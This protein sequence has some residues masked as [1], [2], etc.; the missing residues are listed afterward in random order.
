MRKTTLRFCAVLAF[1]L[2]AAVPEPLDAGALTFNFE[3]FPDRT[4][5]TV[6]Y[7]GIAFTNGIILSAGVTLNEFEFPPHSGSNITSDNGGPIT[8]GFA[9]RFQSFSGYF[10]YGVPITIQAF[11]ASD[12]L[13]AAAASR[14]SN[15]EALSGVTGSQPNELLAVSSS[16]ANIAKVVITGAAGGT[17][18]TMDDI[19][20]SSFSQCDLNQ[21]GNVN[22]V[23][24]QGIIDEDLGVI[25]ATDDLN[26][27]G[28]VNVVD[29][30]IV[31]N[32]ALGWAC[33]AT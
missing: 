32:A 18:F 10:T 17:S 7:A 3:G 14:F 5:L 19:S 6:Q 2:A 23:D 11:D 33:A 30:Q 24:V 1:L 21:D 4:I 27:D 28:A 25:Q 9:A 22:V 15:N 8:I 26:Q 16:A 29:V 13:L 20:A 12:N 31:I